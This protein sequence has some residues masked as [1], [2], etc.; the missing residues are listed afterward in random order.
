MKKFVLLLCI[1]SLSLQAQELKFYTLSGIDRMNTEQFEA[2]LLNLKQKLTKLSKKEM[3][4]TYDTTKMTRLGDTIL[5]FVQLEVMDKTTK[6]LRL[7]SNLHQRKGKKFPDFKLFDIENNLVDMQALKGKPTWINFWFT[8]CGPC[9]DEIPEFNSL[10][11]KYKGKINFVAISFEKRR[12]VEKFLKNQ[13]YDFLQLVD[14]KSFIREL[15]IKAFPK[16]VFLDSQGRIQ[17]IQGGISYEVDATGG[18]S[19]GKGTNFEE[20]LRKLK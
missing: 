19:I 20:I 11:E 14:A 6:K 12:L 8:R 4:V 3:F 17:E 2:K 7:Q 15:G 18:L 10:A 1:G 5:H 16:N 9:V 13:Q